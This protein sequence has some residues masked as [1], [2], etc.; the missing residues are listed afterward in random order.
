MGSAWMLVAGLCF[1]LMSG[2][3][4]QSAHW[5]TGAELVF[6]RSVFAFVVTVVLFRPCENDRFMLIVVVEAIHAERRLI[7][8]PDEDVSRF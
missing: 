4:K 3:V 7:L 8:L 5:F 1:A 2:V 6:Y